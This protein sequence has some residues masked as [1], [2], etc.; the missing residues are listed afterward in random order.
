M[1]NNVIDEFIAGCLDE[2]DR[3]ID[4]EPDPAV[5]RI[6][7]RCRPALVERTRQRITEA[8]SRIDDDPERRRYAT[9]N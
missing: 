1:T 4:A 5:R 7:E 3:L 8:M 2:Y 6:L 9:L